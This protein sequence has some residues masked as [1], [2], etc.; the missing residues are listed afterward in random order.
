MVYDAPWSFC[1]VVALIRVQ[2]QA[3]TDTWTAA[4]DAY[5]WIYNECRDEGGLTGGIVEFET[6]SLELAA[7]EGC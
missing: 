7:G 5:D 4:Q 3:T 6:Y 2:G 1:Y